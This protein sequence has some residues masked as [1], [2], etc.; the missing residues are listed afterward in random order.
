MKNSDMMIII[1]SFEREDL[2]ML[3]EINSF[4]SLLYN[5]K[6]IERVIRSSSGYQIWREWNY[7]YEDAR[8]DAMENIN[9]SDYNKLSLELHH[10]ITLFEI[11]QIQGMML[12]DIN[13]STDIYEISREVIKDHLLGLIPYISLLI[14]SHQKIHCNLEEI[15]KDKIK[16]DVNKFV[17]K[18]KKYMTKEQIELI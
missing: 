14:S 1:N 5:I 18:Y 11:V 15:P 3:L 12:L 7:N 17:N 8:V 13:G 6:E 16:G 10:V 9:T 2:P 4:D